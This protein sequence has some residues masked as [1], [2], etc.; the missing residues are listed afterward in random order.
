MY[1][2]TVYLCLTWVTGYITYQ[3]LQASN[4]LL[5]G[6]EPQSITVRAKY[7]NHIWLPLLSNGV[8]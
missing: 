5:G 6:I 7:V 2:T 1:K 8:S 4:W 3:G